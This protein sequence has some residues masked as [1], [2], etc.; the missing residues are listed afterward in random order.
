VLVAGLPAGA[1]KLIGGAAQIERHSDGPS[2]P[3]QR[4]LA[5]NVGGAKGAGARLRDRE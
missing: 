3:G 4:L 1:R 5:P 2:A